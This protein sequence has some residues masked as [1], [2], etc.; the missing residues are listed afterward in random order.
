[1]SYTAE[2]LKG[3]HKDKASGRREAVSHSVAALGGKLEAMYFAFG[4]DDVCV[5][6][7]LP[8][9]ASAAAFCMAA[10]ASGLVRTHTTPLMTV[11]EADEALK[12]NVDYRAPGHRR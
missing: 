4:Q 6:V 7:D 5:I 1:A 8:D 12:K 9:H 11:D 10:S 2:G 3:L